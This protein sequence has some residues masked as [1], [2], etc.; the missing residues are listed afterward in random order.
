MNDGVWLLEQGPVVQV[1]ISSLRPGDSPRLA[2]ENR[3]YSRI[4]AELDAAALP[5]IVVHRATMRVV[6]GLHRLRAATLRGEDEIQARFCDGDDDEVFVLAV[7]ANVSHGLPLSL[8]DR[9]AA[10]ARIIR[11]HPQRSDRMI[12][13]ATGLAGTT[14]GTI[15]RCSTDQ[16][17][18]LNTRVGRDGR[19]RPVNSAAGR[20]LANELL[21]DYPEASLR[22]IAKAAGIAPATVL[23]VRERVR[24]GQDPVPPKQRRTGVSSSAGQATDIDPAAML[25]RLRRDPSLRFNESGR[26]LLRWLDSDLTGAGWEGVIDNVPA[27]CASIIAELARSKAQE[28]SEFAKQV[29][30]RRTADESTAPA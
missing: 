15:R 8:A 17:A 14:V 5:P 16:F 12:A 23:D 22:D 24:S 10:A 30:R 9:T 26:T 18:Q 29:D 3:Q 7:Q 21:N 27:H 1:P 20:R 19:V 13:A 4:L 28:W 6:D 25:R 11:S 2:G